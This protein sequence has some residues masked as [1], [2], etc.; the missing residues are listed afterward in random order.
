MC[1]QLFLWGRR[2]SSATCDETLHNHCVNIAYIYWGPPIL[3]LELH[4]RGCDCPLLSC[5]PTRGLSNIESQNGKRIKICRFG[6]RFD[7]RAQTRNPLRKYYGTC[8]GNRSCLDHCSSSPPSRR[9]GSHYN[10][11]RWV[12][13]SIEGSLKLFPCHARCFSYS[14]YY[15]HTK[16][17]SENCD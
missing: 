16:G 13:V 3:H 12:L 6:C 15:S 8:M 11:Y 10:C 9:S 4:H 17:K 2:W 7:V 5:M 14:Y 1:L